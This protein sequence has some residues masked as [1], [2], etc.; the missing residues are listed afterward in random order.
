MSKF[1]TFI[2]L[3]QSEYPDDFTEKTEVW[4]RF[5]S[6]KNTLKRLKKTKK[7]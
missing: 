1:D 3:I 4:A 2:T 7:A 6:H 5:D